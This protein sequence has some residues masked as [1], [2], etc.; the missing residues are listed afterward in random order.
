M[1]TTH[2]HFVVEKCLF[3]ASISD[4]FPRISPLTRTRFRA[5]SSICFDVS[6]V[7][8]Q[9]VLTSVGFDVNRLREGRYTGTSTGSL[10]LATVPGGRPCP[11]TRVLILSV[12]PPPPQHQEVPAAQARPSA[13]LF[14]RIVLALGGLPQKGGGRLRRPPP[15]AGKK[16]NQ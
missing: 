16:K 14:A 10:L 2:R 4:E 7:L 3:L 5:S 12:S 9:S 6:R 15:A 1:F 13:P 11:S 8:R